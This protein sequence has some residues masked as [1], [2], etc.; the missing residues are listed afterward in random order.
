MDGDRQPGI[1]TGG[2]QDLLVDTT[3]HIGDGTLVITGLAS[4]DGIASI[5]LIIMG[6][7]QVIIME[8]PITTAT[9]EEMWLPEVD[10]LEVGLYLKDHEWLLADL[11][12][13]IQE[14]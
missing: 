5:T 8:T 4:I 6:F 7:M 9:K 14:T 12:A 13:A 3:I 10:H 2:T 1:C 11:A